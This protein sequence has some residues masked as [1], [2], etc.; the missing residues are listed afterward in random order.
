M[1]TLAKCLCFLLICGALF[2]VYLSLPEQPP[3]DQPVSSSS[4]VPAAQPSEG[5]ATPMT[6]SAGASKPSLPDEVDFNFHIKPILS[7]RCFVCHGPD[8]AT[9]AAGLQL[10]DPE[11]AFGNLAQDGEPNRFALVPNDPEASQMYKRITSQ[12]ANYRMPPPGSN[13]KALNEYQQALVKQWIL[14]G[15]MYKQHWA[16]IKPVKAPPMLARFQ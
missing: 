15:A 16:F 6:V 3:Q 2:C 11:L 9:V 8:K 7:D 10:H 4:D 12:N 14:E 1:H 13:K 5:I